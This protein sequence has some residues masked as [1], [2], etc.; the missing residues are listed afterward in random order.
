[1]DG[2]RSPTTLRRGITELESRQAQLKR[3]MRT[4]V[5]AGL[6]GL[7]GAWRGSIQAKRDV[8]LEDRIAAEHDDSFR[9]VRA[10][11]WELARPERTAQDLDLVEN[12]IETALR[13]VSPPSGLCLAYRLEPG[14]TADDEWAVEEQLAK[15]SNMLA[16]LESESKALWALRALTTLYEVTTYHRLSAPYTSSQP[17][18]YHPSAKQPL[19]L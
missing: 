4:L 6:A 12:D 18:Y 3:V 17:L 2:F 11:A 1:M 9:Q 5:R 15:D 14:Q 7:S 19:T 8:R 16:L 10:T 13:Q